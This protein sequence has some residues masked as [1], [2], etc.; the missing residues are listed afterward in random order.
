MCKHYLFSQRENQIMGYTINT[1]PKYQISTL[2]LD[3]PR[4]FKWDGDEDPAINNFN[5]IDDR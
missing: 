5:K 2:N 4:H 1:N 3:I